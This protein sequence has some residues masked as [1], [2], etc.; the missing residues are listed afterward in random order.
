MKRTDGRASARG[1][2]GLAGAL[3]AS[4]ALW[5]SV[6]AAAEPPSPVSARVAMKADA[7]LIGV[8]RSSG[9]GPVSAWVEFADK[10]ESGI[11]DLERRLT[12][13]EAKLTPRARARRVRAHVDPLVD[14]RDLPV[15]P[16]YVE[17][18]RALGLEPYGV[19][20]WFNQ[21][22]VRV[23]ATGLD[24]VA[25]LPFVARLHAVDHFVRTPEPE[26]VPLDAPPS[27]VGTA[28]A[29][30][31][32]PTINY[33][34]TLNF[35][36][37][38]QVAAVHDSGYIGTGVLICVLDAGFNSWNTHEALASISVPPGHVRDFVEGDTDVTGNSGFNHGG[39]V[40][41]CIAG[42]KPGTYVGTGFGASFALGRTENSASETPAEMVYWMQGAEWADSLGADLISSSLGYSMFD[43][44]NDDYT[45]AD[46]DGHTTTVSRAAEIA[47][48]KGIL[49][50]NSAGN[51][52]SNPFWLKITSP[53]DV[54][55]DSLLAA[56]AVDDFGVRASFS[57]AGPTADKRIKPDLMAAGVLV[58]VIST[59]L[60]TLYTSNSGTSFSAPI[61]A[62]LAAC[63]MQARP[64][65][66][67]SEVIRALR[68][69]GDRWLMPDTLYGYGIANGLAALRWP[70]SVLSVP[71][72]VG[73]PRITLLGPNPFR[74]DGAQTRVR[75][76]LNKD[77]PG[78][79]PGEVR[80]HDAQGRV[81]RRLWRG[82]L[83][84]GDWLTVSWDG[85]DDSAGR[86]SAG[87]YFIA[88]D[89][90]GYHSAVRVAWLP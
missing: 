52:G 73:L 33:G 89:V 81:V 48:S 36:Q 80:V 2:L 54:N 64:S 24:R 79:E 4:G 39:W 71:P 56:G 32:Q 9:G 69:T 63:I 11:V 37:Q 7:R 85:R 14:Y 1:M 35:V 41:G 13:A 62:G 67:P 47:A 87:I 25:Q 27:R 53:A 46:L 22:A 57:S 29:R 49:I 16:A 19:S 21:A 8:L 15:D 6:S 88:L 12:D 82:V 83:P 90:A 18:L 42:N 26:P 74:S 20:R 3:I 23:D 66:T 43:N 84:C 60:P 58:P 31:S 68:E 38:I 44:P 72:P 76:A 34:L 75:F 78:P 50:V 61:L 28:G 65:W 77:A 86:L 70:A 30:Q 45:I 51:E 55:G 10:G 40:L 5:V 59:S 17:A